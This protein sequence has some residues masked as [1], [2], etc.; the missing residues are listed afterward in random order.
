MEILKKLK[1]ELPCDWVIPLLGINPEKTIIQKDTCTPVFIPALFATARTWKHP[2]CPST[3]MDKEGM[4]HIYNEILLSHKKERNWV[5]CRDVDGSR[6]HHTEWN[7]SEREKQT[8]NINTYMW[9]LQKWYEVKWSEVKS[10]SRV[11]LLAIPWTVAYQAP[12]SMGFSRQE[13]WSGLPFPSPGDLPNPGIEPGSTTFQVDALTS[14]PPG[15]P[16]K[17]GIDELISKAEIET[18]M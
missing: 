11:R 9:N 3:E 17:S 16:H 6:D 10:L 4:V 15:K 5:I 13:Y 14:E 8:S 2:K 18:Q 12:P 7:K 1:I